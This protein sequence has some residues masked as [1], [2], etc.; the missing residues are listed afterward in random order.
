M[1]P[2]FSAESLK[3]N[4]SRVIDIIERFCETIKPKDGGWGSK[5]NASEMSTY[6]GF[7]IMGALVFGADFRTV[8]EEGNADLANSVL[9]ASMLM[10]W[11]SKPF[12]YWRHILTVTSGII[13]PTSL[14][15]TPSATY[16][17]LR[18]NRRKVR[19]GQ[20][21]PHQL[22]AQSSEKPTLGAKRREAGREWTN[23]LSIPHRER[24]R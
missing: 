19:N 3:A 17:L 24:R 7:D 5:W 14:P 18:K 10:Y 4:E 15:S 6:L 1:S 12:R 8:Q 2:A 22:L 13:S 21:P 9:P 11:V 16:Q 20:Q 23:R